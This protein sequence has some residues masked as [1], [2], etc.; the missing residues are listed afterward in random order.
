[1]NSET[2]KA[3]LEEASAL[4]S[5]LPEGIRQI[6][7]SKAFD[8]LVEHREIPEQPRLRA[9]SKR[10]PAKPYLRGPRRSS[11]THRVGPKFALGQLLDDGYFATRRGLP[12]I[13]AY[14]RDSHG[15]DYGSN[16]LSISL[17]RLIR[18]GRLNRERDSGGQYE[19]WTA[20]RRQE[21]P[22]SEGP[23]IRAHPRLLTEGKGR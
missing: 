23:G 19:Y 21:G 14:L 5:F 10:V 8:V 15:H 9:A 16:E 4:T 6:A 18:E 12:E 3:V 11:R 20:D 22:P 2:L 17:L 1:M 7:F 13:Q